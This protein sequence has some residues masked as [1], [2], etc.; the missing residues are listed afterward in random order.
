LLGHYGPGSLKALLLKED[1]SHHYSFYADSSVAGSVIFVSFTLTERGLA[2]VDSV[3]KYFFAYLGSVRKSGVDK[4]LLSSIQKL[5]QVEFDYQEKKSSEYDLVHSLAGALPS[6][7]PEDVLTAGVL[8]DKPDEDLIKQ[9]FESLVPSNMNMALLKPGFDEKT[10][11]QREPYYNFSYAE[12]ALEPSLVTA[13]STASGFGLAPPPALAYVPEKLNLVGES[14]GSSGPEQLATAG[15]VQGWWLGNGGVQLPKAVVQ[16]KIGFPASVI[17]RLEDSVM[18]AM[19]V[20]IVNHVLEQPSD[21]LQTCGLYYSVSAHSD[22]FSVHFSGFDQHMLEL[23]KMVLP[24]MHSPGQA[25][26]DVF[27][28]TRRQLLLDLSDITRMQPYQHAMEAFE[29]VTIKGRYSRS[30]LQ[31]AANDAGLVNPEAYERFLA[32]V[33]ADTQVSLLVTG[34]IGRERTKQITEAVADLLEVP[35]STGP[36]TAGHIAM[37]G[38]SPVLNPSHPLEVRIPNPIP[39]DPNSA[40]LVTYQFGIPSIEDRVHLAMLSEVINRPVFE[41]L[42]TERQLGYVVFG[43]V[44]P[45]GSIVEVRVIVQGFREGPDVVGALIDQTISNLTRR[46]E[47]LTPDEVAAR[48][49]SLLTTLSKQP[50]SLGQVAGRY[51]GQIWEGTHCFNKKALMIAALEAEEASK[52]SS[53]SLLTTWKRAVAPGSG[54]PKK[55]SVKLFGAGVDRTPPAPSAAGTAS[56]R[57]PIVL[58]DATEMRTKLRNEQFWPTDFVCN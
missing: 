20:R 13:L 40:T 25:G 35:T 14:A 12:E 5:R 54:N 18:A 37:A 30:E 17:S 11:T 34:N 51:W 6:Y 41:A 48:R 22:G 42:R 19:H 28:L 50:T 23:I 49:Q 27:E 26:K 7:A 3:L 31:R 24:E 58:A 21:A 39:G 57:G 52:A 33:F 36:N 10:A 47:A 15:R 44:A 43:Y 45:H 32:E 9:L 2:E 29:A 1:L 8:I 46:I 56:E 55:V 38:S 53:A 4:K 16:L